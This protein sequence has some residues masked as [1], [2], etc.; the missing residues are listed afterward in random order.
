[1]LQAHSLLW[2]YLWVAPNAL[3]L[4]LAVLL[5]RRGLSRQL[6]AFLAFAVLSA[7]GQFCVFA[8]DVIP[9]VSAETFWYCDWS[10][11]SVASILKFLVIG[12]VFGRVFNP[13]PSVS[14]LGKILLSGV[15]AVL[16]FVATLTAA[17]SQ[18]DS[19]MRLLR[20]AHLLEMST[21]IVECGVI[22]FIFLF[23]AY[24]RMHWDRM[25][26]GILLG[27][28]ISACEHLA[29]WSILT[30]A[31]PSAHQR[32]LIDF[33][34]MGTFHLS[35]LIW[36]WY[37]LKPEKKMTRTERPADPPSP[38]SEDVLQDHEEALKDWNRELERLIHK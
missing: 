28:G 33:L 21:F 12:A 37:L 23:A 19:P 6:P 14:R 13:Y 35:V 16:V 5:W 26:F 18:G 29:T 22:L 8:S 32:T 25:S 27:L 31:D 24:F 1:M 11:L 36:Y 10:D 38:S 20:G 4:I 30:N 2:N 7:V 9:S 34:N 17:F 15:G 3:L